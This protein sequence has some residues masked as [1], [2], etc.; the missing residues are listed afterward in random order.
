VA[1]HINQ[2][3]LVVLVDKLSRTSMKSMYFYFKSIDSLL[4]VNVRSAEY[5]L[6]EVEAIFNATGFNITAIDF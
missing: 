4:E 5:P 2:E 6:N 3:K 1:V